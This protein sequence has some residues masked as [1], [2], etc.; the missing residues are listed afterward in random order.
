MLES[1]QLWQPT[2]TFG[3]PC[4]SVKVLRHGFLSRASITKGDPVVLRHVARVIAMTMGPHGH[5]GP[6]ATQFVLVLNTDDALFV[7]AVL[8]HGSQA[9]I[10][11]FSPAARGGHSDHHHVHLQAPVGVEF[12]I[13]VQLASKCVQ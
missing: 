8:I 10:A 2:R 9:H 13:A 5:N 6:G 4:G 12:L 1:G 11:F 7:S 3:Y